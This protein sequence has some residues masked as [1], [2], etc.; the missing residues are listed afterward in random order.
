MLGEFHGEMDAEDDP[1]LP[2][3]MPKPEHFWVAGRCPLARKV[4][5][6]SH[7]SLI[8]LREYFAGSMIP[9]R[10]LSLKLSLGRLV[11]SRH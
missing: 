3:R 7:V 6:G 5:A 4:L 11:M 10:E 8:M 9:A 2:E 1:V